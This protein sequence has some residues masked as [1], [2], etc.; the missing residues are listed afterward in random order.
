M[1]APIHLNAV[2][3]E[4]AD[5]PAHKMLFQDSVLHDHLE[6]KTPAKPRLLKLIDQM[7]AERISAA[8]EHR[9]IKLPARILP[10]PQK[11]FAAVSAEFDLEKLYPENEVFKDKE[12]ARLQSEL[13]QAIQRLE[14]MPDELA[15][16]AK[17]LA[18]ALDT[19][20]FL[21]KRCAIMHLS[22]IH[23]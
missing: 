18:D 6:C 1:N 13:V 12:L 22:L 21:K 16:K 8:N 19:M 23:I 20:D 11:G 15:N 4:L 2:L 17:H 14:T 3:R 9:A 10:D 7:V 5:P